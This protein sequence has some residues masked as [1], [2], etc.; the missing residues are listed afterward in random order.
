MRRLVVGTAGHVDHGKTSLV[1][2]LTGVDCD[3]WQE[4]KDRG[5]TI[6][7]GF[8]HLRRD[9]LQVGFVDVPGHERFLHNALAGLGGIRLMLLVVAAD[10]GVKPQTREHLD[11]CKLLGIP[12][13]LVALT[14]TDLVSEDLV[15]LAQLEVEEL[16]ADTPYAG[17]P[18]FPVSSETGDGVPELEAALLSLAAEHEVVVDPDRPARL[19]VDR[20]FLLKGLGLVVTG[21]LAS[22]EIRTGE[23]LEL[24]PSGEPV[25][26][27]AVQ[28]HGE[29]RDAAEAGERTSLQVAGVDLDHTRRGMQIVAPGRFET[30]NRLCARLRLLDDAPLSFEGW[31]PIRLHLYAGQV[32][33]ELRPLGAEVLEPGSEGMVEMRLS[34]PVVAARGDRFIVTRPSPATTLGGGWVLDPR[35]RRLRG[36]FL[37]DALNGLSGGRREALRFWVRSAGE[38]GVG[39]TE[40]ARRLGER[41]ER[42]AADLKEMTSEGLLLSVAGGSGADGR[43][44][45]PRAFER[46]QERAKKVLAAY[47]EKD[48]LARGIPKAEAV[49]RILPGKAAELSGTY[50]PWLEAQ[51]VIAVQG[52]LVNLPGRKVEL[53][54]EESS[55][56]KA[57]LD[58]YDGAGLQPPSPSEAS[59]TL[60]A[61]PQ[62]LEG[63]MRVLVE[64]GDLVRLP[65]GLLV[66]ASAL[67]AVRVGLREA[68]WER[69]DVGAFK[70]R[71]GVSR[72][73]AIPLLEHLDSSGVTRRVGDER[74]VV[75]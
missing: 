64:R 14:K 62:I 27:R 16:L 42:V 9:D 74:M 10:E 51:G 5:I 53:S 20:A 15:E 6:D 13:G 17:A 31:M 70:D 43:W 28:V 24:L 29:A 12:G 33:G 60:S 71:F 37:D 65:G 44:I 48:R 68:G 58:L 73:W 4:E 49:K 57:I 38:K 59:V 19:P 46:V 7:L 45:S 50:L 61:K 69:F 52:D 25:K 22:G 55:L 72:K 36:P 56:S 26:V 34:A 32:I 40:L 8:A 35:W 39:A 2:A 66:A 11:I 54:G 21:T 75:R 18:V 30:S 23:A 67:E 63:V 41:P 1:R 3:R 47:F